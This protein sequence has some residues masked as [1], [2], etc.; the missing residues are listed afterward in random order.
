MALDIYGSDTWLGQNGPISLSLALYRC[1]SFLGKREFRDVNSH[2]VQ[3]F[4]LWPQITAVVYTRLNWD[5][6]PPGH[7]DY[8]LK[9]V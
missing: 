4:P 2:R 1:V 3:N 5:G 9:F 6:F 7:W 8:L